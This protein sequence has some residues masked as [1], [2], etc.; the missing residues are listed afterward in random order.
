[1]LSSTILLD[2]VYLVKILITLSRAGLSCSISFHHL[3][4]CSTAKSNQSVV[5]LTFPSLAIYI[6]KA[7]DSQEADTSSIFSNL[8]KLDTDVHQLAE[9][10][11]LR[12]T[13]AT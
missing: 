10:A 4:I 1:M 7:A 9:N 11:S 5:I 6:S 3:L 13:E 8:R 12:V 2:L